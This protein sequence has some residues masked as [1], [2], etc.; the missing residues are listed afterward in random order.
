MKLFP[1]LLLRIGGDTFENLENLTPPKTLKL[2]E[3]LFKHH[4]IAEAAKKNISEFLYSFI[5]TLDG[6]DSQNLMLSLRR[7]VFNDRELDL[8]FIKACA[9]V[10]PREQNEVFSKYLDARKEIDK[11]IEDGEEVYATET[12]LLRQKFQEL[13]RKDVLKLGLL[14][15]SQTLLNKVEKY[16]ETHPNDF[17]KREFHTEQSLLKYL[18]R[19]FAK[20]SPFSTFTHLGVGEIHEKNTIDFEGTSPTFKSHI[21]LNNYL[22][23]YLKTILLR[24]EPI[25]SNFTIRLNPTLTSK[26]E[27]YVFLTNFNNMESFQRIDASPLIDLFL[28]IVG[29][30]GIVYKE[31]I[32]TIVKEEYI[33]ASADEIKGFV[34]QLLDYGLLEFDLG[35]SGIDPGWDST[36]CTNLSKIE[37][38]D[39]VIID[40]INTLKETRNLANKFGEA[41]LNER[42][43]LIKLAF[44]TFRACCWRLHEFAGLPEE[45]RLEQDDYVAFAKK[46]LKDEEEKD[47]GED[48]VEEIKDI[49]EKV[50]KNEESTR[51][52]FKA[53]QLFYEDCTSNAAP[54]LPEKGLTEITESVNTLFSNLSLFEGHQDET[55]KMFEFFERHYPNQEKVDLFTFYEDYFREI[56]KPEAEHQQKQKDEAKKQKEDQKKEKANEPKTLDKPKLPDHLSFPKVEA[57]RDLMEKWMI[58]YKDLAHGIANNEE[59]H[60][61]PELLKKV[62]NQLGVKPHKGFNATSTG[63]FIQPFVNNQGD[64][65]ANLNTTFP[66]FG[67]LFTRFLHTFSA[68]LTTQIR[69]WNKMYSNNCMLAENTDGSY[70]NANLHPTLMPY[71]VKI[72][73]GHN[74]L[75]AEAQIPI[76]QVQ[77]VKVEGENRLEIRHRET[78]KPIYV[79][80][81]C[82]QSL[83]S[84][85][86]LYQLLERFS[87]AEFVNW[88]VL[89][90]PINEVADGT[91][92]RSEYA[93]S[94]PDNPK[95][96]K[97]EVYTL[98]RITF[99]KNLILQRKSWNIPKKLIPLRK[100][101]ETSWQYFSRISIWRKE[102]GIPRHSF[103][104]IMD[105]F[106]MDQLTPKESEKI[107]RDDYKPQYLDF[108]NPIMINLF[109]KLVEKAPFRFKV[110]E[111]L[112]HPEN[113]STINGKKYVTE[114]LHQWYN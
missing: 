85:S 74:S 102:L 43:K 1:K 31:M 100:P 49:E 106:L 42:R 104:F 56:K 60:I 35:V 39:P 73:G 68:D 12:T 58:T 72:P 86:Q 62:N 75:S 52:S 34:G 97:P 61:S 103:V 8:D 57:R 4:S 99:N 83:A 59:V 23:H 84:R 98:P 54:K 24:V 70:F 101:T 82:F 27:Q 29:Q 41:Q 7:D 91:L 77:V 50:F 47:K 71:E 63:A 89:M 13:T 93:K 15:S 108:D 16:N 105:R 6:S 11:I 110:E 25:Y 88:G 67:K 22:L 64:F 94:N 76:A 92:E 65:H 46:K 40:L 37:K 17:K 111:M 19:I 45:E 78:N 38:P 90:H 95:K 112:P 10:L 79:F 107:G 28:E 109:E 114:Y 87:I 36:L 30:K 55:L 113:M 26:E 96:Y 2:T 81:L 5:P 20:T 44:N 80:D 9:D 21:C 3:N 14:L 18:T 32:D 69:E 51:F 33:D 48:K 53:E 66:G